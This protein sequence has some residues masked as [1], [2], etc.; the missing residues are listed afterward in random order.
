M[1]RLFRREKGSM[2]YAAAMLCLALAACAHP[3]APAAPAA[4]LQAMEDA[5]WHPARLGSRDALKA[6]FAPDFVSVE[7]GP[8]PMGFTYRSVGMPP[9]LDAVADMLDKMRFQATEWRV[10][11]LADGAVLLSY[12]IT[13]PT[14]QWTAYASSVWVR[15]DGRWQTVYYQ[16]S[17]ARPPAP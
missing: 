14:L 12:R 16:A 5:K 15:R 3:G 17:R 6:L 9:A 10:V 8:D 4:D 2:R 11:P 1:M 13:E 7:Y